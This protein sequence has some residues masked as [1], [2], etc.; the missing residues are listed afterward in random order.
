MVE[1]ED[2]FETLNECENFIF[3]QRVIRSQ[4]LQSRRNNP[5]F[6]Y[7]N[8]KVIVF[9]GSHKMKFLCIIDAALI[10]SS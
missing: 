5:Y 9:Q 3:S 4:N 7:E 1:K 8:F 2:Y 10:K 6:N